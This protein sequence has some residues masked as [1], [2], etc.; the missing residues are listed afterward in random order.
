MRLVKE[1]EHKW[2]EERLREV[3]LFSLEKRSFLG[4]LITLYNYLKEGCSQRSGGFT[5]P[6]G[7]KM[8]LDAATQC[9]DL[10]I[11]V[12]MDQGLDLMI[13]EVFSNLADSMIL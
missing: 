11:T 1:L 13:S 3:E 7:F 5:I 4:D 2:Y 9:C 8:R 10:A 12:V 6:G